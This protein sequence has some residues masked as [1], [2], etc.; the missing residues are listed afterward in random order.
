[1]IWMGRVSLS[2]RSSAASEVVFPTPV[3]P[4]TRT[5]PFLS[6][7]IFRNASG[8]LRSSMDGIRVSSF[9]MTIEP[10]PLSDRD[11]RAQSHAQRPPPDP[12]RP[13]PGVLRYRLDASH[14]LPLP[15]GRSTA[16]RRPDGLPH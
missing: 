10:D 3:G 7:V 2:S 16:G 1:M 14:P 6:L 12:H 4:D 15:V 13:A 11:P 5:R 9:R 8:S